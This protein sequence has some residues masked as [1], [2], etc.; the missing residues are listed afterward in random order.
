M[1]DAI[2]V[3]GAGPGPRAVRSCLLDMAAL[4]LTTPVYWVD[5]TGDPAGPAAVECIAHAEA[6]GA[7]VRRMSLSHA[8]RAMGRGRV[9]LI[10]LD[11]PDGAGSTLDTAGVR[12]FTD[13]I[14][15]ILPAAARRVHLY[16]PR[17]PLPQQPP[18]TMPGWTLLVVSPEDSEAP[19]AAREVQYRADG[20]DALARYVTPAVVG[21]TGLWAHSTGVPVCDAQTSPVTGEVGVDAESARLVRVF[22]RHI[23]ATEV[24]RELRERVLDVRSAVPQ[25]RLADGRHIVTADNPAELNRRVADSFMARAETEGAR[26]PQTTV[27]GGVDAG[28][29]G[30]F[31]QF[32]EYVTGAV[33]GNSGRWFDTATAT[34]DCE[35]STAVHRAL[36]IAEES[37]APDPCVRVL[38]SSRPQSLHSVADAAA[39]LRE[40]LSTSD[41]IVVGPPPTAPALW[42]TYTATTLSLVDGKERDSSLGPVRDSNTN[43]VVVP[44]P[45]LAAPDVADSFSGDHPTL[46]ELLG[47][48]LGP[49]TISPV[50]PHGAAHYAAALQYAASQTT[51][52]SIATK[53]REFT[54][55]RQQHASSFAW[56][57]GQRLSGAIQDGQDRA[58]A[59]YKD[60]LTTRAALGAFAGDDDAAAHRGLA[61]TMRAVLLVWL[62]VVVGCLAAAL[63][64]PRVAFAA[65]VGTAGVATVIALLAELAIFARGRDAVVDRVSRRRAVW[66]RHSA[67]AGAFVAAVTDLERAAAAY[68]QHQ[69]WS[70]IIGRAIHHPFGA[71]CAEERPALLPTAGLPRASIIGTAQPD[72]VAMRRAV[73]DLRATVFT[74]DWADIAVADLLAAASAELEQ[75]G[76]FVPSRSELFG[77]PAAG[78]HSVLCRLAEVASDDGLPRGDSAQVWSPAVASYVSS[79]QAEALLESVRSIDDGQPVELSRADVLADVLG[80]TDAGFFRGAVSARGANHGAVEVDPAASVCARYPDLSAGSGAAPRA[81]TLSQAV[82]VVQCGHSVRPEWFTGATVQH[83]AEPDL[84]LPGQRDSLF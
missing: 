33:L 24:E 83:T 29:D 63:L 9:V 30:F 42:R 4:G 50:D 12:G 62:V 81:A 82:T 20:P 54:N 32:T 3:L 70:T 22:H 18:T 13:A 6:G 27:P 5:P 76:E 14:D 78:A 7:Q 64:S 17:L 56:Q 44:R 23:D 25:P 28:A 57:V 61:R 40:Q 45:G 68:R 48:S 38:T 15:H 65:G 71:G 75:R 41:A 35:T 2:V 39:S 10:A 34:A 31:S 73:Q 47:D 80:T 53:K 19:D 79:G 67:A 51:D 84:E 77:Q 11:E 46:R 8:T 58:R 69:V 55:W 49:T 66:R 43:P 74:P 59:A 26:P 72:A 37:A 52:Q 21:M 1:S 60:V 16:L 36:G